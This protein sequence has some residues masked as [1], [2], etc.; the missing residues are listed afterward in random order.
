MDTISSVQKHFLNLYIK[1]PQCRLGYGSS[2]QCDSF[3]LGEMLRFLTRKGTILMES[4]L[5]PSFEEA[6]SYTGSINDVIAR[7]RECPSYQ[8]DENHS[9]C[10]LRTRL[11]PILDRLDLGQVAMCLA[12]WDEDRVNES[13]VES[14]GQESWEFRKRDRATGCQEHRDAKAMFTAGKRD[15]TP[16]YT[17]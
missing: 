6:E 15:W 17:G 8:I 16:A 10:G 12:C 11:L 2:P 4:A 14:P 3:Q 5:S 9:H 7:L 13:W 1:K